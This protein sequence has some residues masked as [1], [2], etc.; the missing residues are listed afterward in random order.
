M[1]F[2]PKTFFDAMSIWPN[3]FSSQCPSIWLENVLGYNISS[4]N[5]FFVHFKS[6]V[7]QMYFLP[8]VF[9]QST[10]NPAHGQSFGFWLWTKLGGLF[11]L[12]IFFL[13]NG[14]STKL[15]FGLKLFYSVTLVIDCHLLSCICLGFFW[16]TKS[17]IFFNSEIFFEHSG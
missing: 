16:K 7:R 8:K 1:P 10:N 4:T 2:C 15:F 14:P 17:E 12:G 5:D 6:I 13:K 3:V 11:V 9:D